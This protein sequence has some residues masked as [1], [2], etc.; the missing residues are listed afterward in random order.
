MFSPLRNFQVF[1]TNKRK[2]KKK[3][4][5]FV[6]F[7]ISLMSLVWF[8]LFVYPFSHVRNIGHINS[9]LQFTTQLIIYGHPH[10]T[11]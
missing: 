3:I 8:G 11:I 7:L 4:V 1:E 6:K 5:I 2:L 9:R 10:N